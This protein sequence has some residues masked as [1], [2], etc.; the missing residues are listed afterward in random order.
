MKKILFCLLTF[1]IGGVCA[2]AAPYALDV[3]DFSEIKLIDG[4]NVTYRCMPDS[5]GWV[6][7]DCEESI[8][9]KILF[10]NTKNK[11]KIELATDGQVV[12]NLPMITVYSSFLA[13]AEN[14]GDSTLTV[15]SPAAASEF[16]ARIIGNGSIV[17]T[18]LHAT[19][20]EG[21]I[22]TGKGHLVL[23]G[24]ARNVVLS[25]T[26]TGR[27]EA[28]SLSA[29]VGKCKLF[30]TGPID[31][32]VSKELTVVGLGSGTVYLKGSPTIKNRTLGVKI[33]TV[34]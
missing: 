20:V 7:F 8:A 11:L 14:S 26:G 15:I 23:V 4:I 29:E 5:A 21:K 30:G 3:K 2:Q 27:I 18:G 33:E 1:F 6:T 10:S 31:C 12:K 32:C 34:D 25:N 24:K 13:K 22:D 28:G 16:S 9:N 19:K 17:A